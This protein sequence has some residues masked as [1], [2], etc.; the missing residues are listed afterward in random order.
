MTSIAEER[1]RI[2][3]AQAAKRE[4][5]NNMKTGFEKTGPVDPPRQPAPGLLDAFRSGRQV[6][7]TT[8]I[9]NVE[10]ASSKGGRTRRRFKKNR[11]MSRKYCKK[12]PCRRMGFTQKASCRPYKNCYTRRK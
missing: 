1:D 4:T 9:R 11:L 6:K 12:T 5:L 3:L 7:G 10:G 2:R 8:E